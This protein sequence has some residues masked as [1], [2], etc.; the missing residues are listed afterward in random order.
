MFPVPRFKDS[1]TVVDFWGNL[2]VVGA[3]LL[4]SLGDNRMALETVSSSCLWLLRINASIVGMYAKSLG[5]LMIAG[6]HL[7]ALLLQRQNTYRVSQKKR[8]AFE[9]LLL[10]DYIR[11]DILQYLIK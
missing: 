4:G 3:F 7:P 11:N 2:A 9:R 6:T 1:R 8:P 10:P 5:S